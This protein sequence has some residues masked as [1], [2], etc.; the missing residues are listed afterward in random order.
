MGLESACDLTNETHSWND[1]KRRIVVIS[2]E[3]ECD[4]SRSIALVEV[5]DKGMS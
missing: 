4:V 2:E 1:E 3:S 5:A